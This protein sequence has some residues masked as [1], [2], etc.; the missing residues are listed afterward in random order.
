VTVIARQG[1]VTKDNA[2]KTASGSRCFY[3]GGRTTPPTCSPFFAGVAGDWRRKGVRSRRWRRWLSTYGD[4]SLE[5]PLSDAMAAFVR[6]RA[7]DKAEAKPPGGLLS[8][9]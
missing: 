6:S 9:V 3:S 4:F 5:P 7:W 8:A 2:I 1:S